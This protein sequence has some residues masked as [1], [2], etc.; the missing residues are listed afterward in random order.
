M[1]TENCQKKWRLILIYEKNW[2][3]RL[4]TC[5]FLSSFSSSIFEF[6]FHYFI[7]FITVFTFSFFIIFFSI[8]F[9][10]RF[11]DII[12][13]MSLVCLKLE[14]KSW[15]S[16]K[17]KAKPWNQFLSNVPWP[18]FTIVLTWITINNKTPA[19]NGFTFSLK[20][21]SFM[22][23]DFFDTRNSVIHRLQTVIPAY[24]SR[25]K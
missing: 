8:V 14:E 3:M 1:G 11:D 4:A 7:L 15:K 6:V 22:T 10:F 24:L 23:Y 13:V 16:K 18:C 2:R 9:M 19:I 17:K 25:F 12:R 21:A 20:S 5:I